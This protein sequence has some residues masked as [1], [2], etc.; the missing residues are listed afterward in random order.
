LKPLS[1]HADSGKQS[2]IPKC[3]LVNEVVCACYTSNTGK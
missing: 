3:A 2:A 1:F